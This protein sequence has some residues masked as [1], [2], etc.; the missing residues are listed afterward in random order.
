MKTKLVSR[1]S[2]PKEKKGNTNRT[3]IIA[4]VVIISVCFALLASG[5]GLSLSGSPTFIDKKKLYKKEGEFYT[6]KGDKLYTGMCKVYYS[7]GKVK[8]IWALKDG[9]KDGKARTFYASG[10][11]ESVQHFEKGEFHGKFIKYQSNGFKEAETHFVRGIEHGEFTAY[12][13]TGEVQKRLRINEGLI[14]GEAFLYYRNGKVAF[15]GWC[16][17]GKPTGVFQ[18]FDKEG[19]SLEPINYDRL[20]K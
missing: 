9:K 13:K 3:I 17:N 10:V 1:R 20:T 7:S 6:I 11:L 19:N 2:K 8:E 14:S 16:E 5:A 15:K 18:R 12:Y 4:L